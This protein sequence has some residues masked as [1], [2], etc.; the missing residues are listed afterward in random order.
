MAD[1]GLRQAQRAGDID[2]EHRVHRVRRRAE[3]LVGAVARRAGVIPE[4]VDRLVDLAR[5]ARGVFG[6][7]LVEFVNDDLAA[8]R[9]G[10]GLEFIGALG[11]A[12][13]G[14]HARA[15]VRVLPDML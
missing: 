9:I 12:A 6:P 15:L 10:E 13:A 4:D 14:V 7:G 3:H 5:Q 1:Q 11:V 8:G 2:V